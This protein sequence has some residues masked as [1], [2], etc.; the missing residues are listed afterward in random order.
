MRIIFGSV[1]FGTFKIGLSR[2]N[3]IVVIN[4]MLKNHGHDTFWTT[5]NVYEAEGGEL[6]SE[7]VTTPATIRAIN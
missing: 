5:R 6:S 2:T 7:Y 3:L 1:C 4:I